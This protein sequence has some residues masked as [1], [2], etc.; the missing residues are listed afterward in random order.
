MYLFVDIPMGFL[1]AR[2]KKDEIKLKKKDLFQ[3][4]NK[5]FCI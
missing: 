4:N 5:L 1:K 3:I 2:V